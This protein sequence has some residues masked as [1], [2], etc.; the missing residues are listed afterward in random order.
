LTDVRGILEVLLIGTASRHDQHLAR[1]SDEPFLL[2]EQLKLT[3]KEF[4][5]FTEDPPSFTDELFDRS[6]DA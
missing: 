5:T 3:E 4:V 6:M 2:K 1:E